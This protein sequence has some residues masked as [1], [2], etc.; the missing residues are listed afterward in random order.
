MSSIIEF[1][2]NENQEFIELNKLLKITGL[3]GTGGEANVRILEGEVKVNDNIATEKRKKIRHND[4]VELD[5]ITIQ[6]K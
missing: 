6:V 3:V 1:T 4:I 2:I 5:G